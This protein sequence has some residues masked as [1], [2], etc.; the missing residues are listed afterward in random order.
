MCQCHADV[1]VHVD[2]NQSVQLRELCGLVNGSV[3]ALLLPPVV[4]VVDFEK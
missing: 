4:A 3:C 2:V 1:D